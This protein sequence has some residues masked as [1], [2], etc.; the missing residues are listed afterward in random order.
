MLTDKDTPDPSLPQ[1][2]FV[3]HG[4]LSRH[5]VHTPIGLDVALAQTEFCL[6]PGLQLQ[7]KSGI[8][9]VLVA[10]EKRLRPK[11]LQDALLQFVV[12]HQKIVSSNSPGFGDARLG[13]VPLLAGS[14]GPKQAGERGLKAAVLLATEGADPAEQGLVCWNVG[15]DGLKD[16]SVVLVNGCGQA[17][18]WLADEWQSWVY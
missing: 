17:R 15:S 1:L 6:Q 4:F 8:S 9:N 11:N 7:V 10:W 18:W 12:G 2:P 13:K 16:I 5:S 3:G 14:F